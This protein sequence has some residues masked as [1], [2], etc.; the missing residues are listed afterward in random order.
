MA[1]KVKRAATSATRPFILDNEALFVR[2]AAT[3]GRTV[4][5]TDGSDLCT[6][7][8]GDLV[9]DGVNRYDILLLRDS[10]E[11]DAINSGFTRNRQIQIEEVVDGTTLRF[12][13]A[14]DLDFGTAGA[15]V[16]A[17][18]SIVRGWPTYPSTLDDPGNYPSGSRMYGKISNS[19][20][21]FSDGEPANKLLDG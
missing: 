21:Q 1:S 5:V 12:S 18:W 15:H 4:T 17:E 19:S 3:F 16:V 6:F 13:A 8:S 9:S 2:V 7:A 20:E 10:T 11:T 14:S